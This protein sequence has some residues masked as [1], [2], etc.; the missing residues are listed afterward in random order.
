MQPK[1]LNAFFSIGVT[2]VLSGE[3]EVTVE[4]HEGAVGGKVCDGLHDVPGVLEPGETGKE[5]KL[6][7]HYTQT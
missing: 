7:S 1:E 4:Q 2:V 6:D 5:P 3:Q